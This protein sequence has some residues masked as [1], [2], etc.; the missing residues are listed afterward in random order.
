MF[1]QVLKRYRETHYITQAQLAERVGVSV[2]TIKQYEGGHREP[3]VQNLAMFPYVVIS[4][5]IFQLREVV[6]KGAK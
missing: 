4:E 1:G 5:Y 2:S 6:L 3:S